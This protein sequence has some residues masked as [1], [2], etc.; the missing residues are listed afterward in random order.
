M[1]SG[2]LLVIDARKP[3]MLA[4][5]TFPSKGAAMS[6]LALLCNVHVLAMVCRQAKGNLT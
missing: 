1:E 6:T 4:D 3:S 5:F 2:L